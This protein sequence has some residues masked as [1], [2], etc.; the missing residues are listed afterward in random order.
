METEFTQQKIDEIVQSIEGIGRAELS[1]FFY[2]RLRA[3]L[4]QRSS[5][6]KTRLLLTKPAFSFITVSL[7]IILNIAAI[8]YY[9]KNNRQSAVGDTTGIQ[10]FAQEYNIAVSSLYNDKTT[11]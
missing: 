11:K 5:P 1:P 2:T 3:R 10:N 6:Q 7:L 9:V 8:N 4:D